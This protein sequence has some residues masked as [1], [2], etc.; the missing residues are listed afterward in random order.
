MTIWWETWRY[1]I[2]L[3]FVPDI[4]P[5]A[6]LRDLLTQNCRKKSKKGMVHFALDYSKYTYD[7]EYNTRAHLDFYK[8]WFRCVISQSGPSGPAHCP[9]VSLLHEFRE[10]I[11]FHLR[12]SP[13][14]VSNS[15]FLW[16][17]F[18]SKMTYIV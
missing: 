6:V 18:F 16:N 14:S 8:N 9:L 11:Y 10:L 1:R 4:I 7:N 17:N 15:C 2:S 3:F 13:N 5:M 12:I